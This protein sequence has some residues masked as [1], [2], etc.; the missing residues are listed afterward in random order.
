M[1]IND[2]FY[3]TFKEL[4]D[5]DMAL[6]EK[7]YGMTDCFGYATGFRDFSDIRQRLKSAEPGRLAFMI[8]CPDKKSPAGF[9]FGQ[10]KMNNSEA[11]LWVYILIIEPSFQNKGLGT[12][13]INNL[14][15]Y[16]KTKYGIR[17]CLVSVSCRNRKGL[18]FWEKAG[19][20]RSPSL[21]QHL[22][23]YG[24]NEVAILKKIIC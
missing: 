19:F 20:S 15:N 23:Q 10:V 6:L 24:T 8:N 7:W 17:A 12:L 18:S 1:N 2:G 5:D 9:V 14:L 21:E 22:Q 3:L 4:S 16:A 11:V 13:T